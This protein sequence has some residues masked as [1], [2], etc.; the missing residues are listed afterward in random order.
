MY[1]ELGALD[2]VVFETDRPLEGVLEADLEGLGFFGPLK[3]IKINLKPPKFIREAASRI[4]RQAGEAA[5]KEI[6]RQ[7]QKIQQAVQAYK[8]YEPQAST[9]TQVPPSTGGI[10]KELLLAGLALLLLMKR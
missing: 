7:E 5:G 2:L 1:R 8:S 9:A 4:F 6:K 3:K 10:P